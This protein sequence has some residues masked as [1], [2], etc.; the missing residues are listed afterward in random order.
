MGIEPTTFCLQDKCSTIELKKQSAQRGIRTPASMIVGLKS[1]ALNHSAICAHFQ[2][3][4]FFIYKLPHK[5][6]IIIYMSVPLNPESF[7]SKNGMLTKVWG[8]PL[9]HFLHTVSFNYPVDPTLEDKQHY[10]EFILQLQHVLPCGKCRENLKKN[11]EKLPIGMSD[12]QSRH[13]FSV[14][15]YNLHETVNTML[16]KSS[17][18]T[19]EIVRNRYEG[20]R[21]N[22]LISEKKKKKI[23]PPKEQGCVKSLY[24]VKSRCI[25]NIVPD[26]N[27]TR[28]NSTLKIHSKCKFDNC[29]KSNTN[30]KSKSMK[31][32]TKN[33]SGF[34]TRH[35]PRPRKPF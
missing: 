2:I 30:M 23:P 3:L 19:Y 8:P 4:H 35:S 21:A 6:T 18:L 15:I 14:Y 27:H 20:F 1:T 13:T 17:G 5:Y 7:N 25:M 22:C 9:W 31:S 29:M 33:S 26:D 32:N 12:M 16:G 28:K 34:K 10:M 11:F 24:H